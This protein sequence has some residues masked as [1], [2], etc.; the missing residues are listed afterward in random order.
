MHD[1]PAGQSASVLQHAVAEVQ[2]AS[3]HFVAVT[4]ILDWHR[5][6]LMHV[7]QAAP[8]VVQVG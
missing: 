4:D 3:M 2:R 6:K 7:V 1:L 8:T 5:Q